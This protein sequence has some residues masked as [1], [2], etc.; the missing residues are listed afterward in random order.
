MFNTGTNL[1]AQFLIGNLGLPPVEDVH[2]MDVPG[3]KHRPL[4]KKE[5]WARSRS[6]PNGTSAGL[7]PFPIVIIRDPFRFMASMCKSPYRAV[8]KRGLD[9][10]CPNLVPSP[11]ERNRSGYRNVN[12]TFEVTIDSVRYESLA[13]AWSSFYREYV[14][15]DMPRLV[16]RY[17][18]L[19][20][21]AEA[22]AHLVSECVGLP[23]PARVFYPLRPSKGH[24]R[25]VEFAAAGT[26]G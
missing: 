17:E 13:A 12:S 1:L 7:R 19:L 2:E 26:G 16:V 10:H 6:V 25:P 24:G 3:G 23:P 5:V 4:G 18:D 15:S 8:W 22:V 20:H 14:A 11:E 9:G 21:H